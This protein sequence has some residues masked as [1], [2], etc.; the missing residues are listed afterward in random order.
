MS[1]RRWQVFYDDRCNLCLRIVHWLRRL[2]RRH[3]LAFLPF[4]CASEGCSL[5]A[6][7]VVSPE[8]QVFW[9]LD[10]I[11]ALMYLCPPLRP[12]AWLISLLPLRRLGW[13]LYRFIAANRYR[14][15]GRR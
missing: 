4:P 14:L 15:F 12:F 1:R 6:V 8:G 7:Q 10:G 9:G 11:V 13:R 5:D 2:D 3:C